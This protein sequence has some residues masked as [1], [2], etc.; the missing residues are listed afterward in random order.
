VPESAPGFGDDVLAALLDH[1]GVERATVVG[2]SSGGSIGY[3]FAARFPD[4]V[5]ALIVA[6]A[7]AN[8]LTPPERSPDL[9]AEFALA[10]A[11]GFKRRAYWEVYL[12]WLAG[13]PAR[14]RDAVV[15]KYYDLNRREPEPGVRSFWRL[16]N[17]PAR[18][19]GTL[20]AVAAPTLLVWGARDLVLPLP[21]LDALAGY[22]TGTQ[23]S[24]LVL[25]DVG[26]YPPIEVPGRFADI[27]TTCLDAV[28]P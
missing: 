2:V 18:T 14:V 11:T 12:R 20:A 4:R 6:N 5:N 9:A 26:H 10:A 13:D 23:V 28:L 8:P 15:E 22:L 27:V 3:W 7:P 24:R 16:S 17:E 25:P 21:A 19:Q 1:V